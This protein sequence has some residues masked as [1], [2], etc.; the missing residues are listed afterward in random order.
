[1]IDVGYAEPLHNGTNGWQFRLRLVLELANLV[2]LGVA[3]SLTNYQL[4]PLS[5]VLQV[6]LEIIWDSLTF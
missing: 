1:M 5:F 4:I 6:A 3:I 2:C